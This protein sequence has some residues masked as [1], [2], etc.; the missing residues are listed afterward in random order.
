MSVL[1]CKGRYCVR[2]PSRSCTPCFMKNL[3]PSGCIYDEN[4]AGWFATPFHGTKIRN[5][6]KQSSEL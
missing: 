4:L 6:P 2:I 3:H 1:G 5:I